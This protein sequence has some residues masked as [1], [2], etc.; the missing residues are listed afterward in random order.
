MPQASTHNF[1]LVLGRLVVDGGLATQN[2][3][4]QCLQKQNLQSNDSASK[5]DN[6]ADMLVDSGFVTKH[7]IERIK[8]KVEE[9]HNT[10]QI[11]GFKFIKPLGAGAMAKVYLAKQLSLDRLVAIKVLPNKFIR[12]E[13]FVEPFDAEGKAAAKL[14]HPNI[15][16]A[17]DVGKS[18]DTP[19]VVV[20]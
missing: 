1:D 3:V 17:L 7:Q 6:L 9:Q 11:P 12:N 8:P 18:G 19:Y 16:G 20:E 5:K 13:Q 10:W 4:D 2:E 15:V 14:N